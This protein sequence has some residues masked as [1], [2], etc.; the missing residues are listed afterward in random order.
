MRSWCGVVKG[1]SQVTQHRQQPWSWN[2]PPEEHVATCFHRCLLGVGARKGDDRNAVGLSVGLECS[3]DLK[4]SLIRRPQV[5]DYEAGRDA[6]RNVGGG[7][8]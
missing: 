8:A 3:H 5:D 2:R 1:L 6:S 7:R 4:A